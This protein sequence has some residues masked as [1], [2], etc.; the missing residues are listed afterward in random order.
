M[1]I[2]LV[3][4]PN[5]GKSQV[6]SKLT[7]IDTM[8]SNYSGTSLETT[9]G[10]INMSGVQ[11]ELVDTP[12]IYSL[13]LAEG[14]AGVTREI[15]MRKQDYDLIIN[16]VDA[17]KLGR[18]LA[19]TLELI[20][21]GL[22][23]IVLLNQIEVARN[24]HLE[25][26]QQKLS[27]SLGCPVIEFSAHTGEGMPKLLEIL[28][29][30]PDSS[31][32]TRQRV[33]LVAD[34]PACGCDGD[35]FRCFDDK[36]TGNCSEQA[37]FNRYQQARNLA[38]QVLL[39]SDRRIKKLERLEWF[40]DNTFWGTLVLL[41]LALIG[42]G[43]LLTFVGW[44][45]GL[46]SQLFEPVQGF[47]S[48]V[49]SSIIPPGFWNSILSKGVPEGLLIPFSLVMP[50]M[51]MVSFLMSLIEDIGLLPRYAVMLDRVGRVFGV[52]GQAVIPL[53]LGFGCRT[54]AVTATRILPSIGQRFIIITLLSIVIPCAGTIGMLASTIVALDAYTPVIVLTMTVV[55][56]LLGWV[57]KKIYGEEE[58]P[59][60]ELPSLRMP[61]T[62]N[63]L[64]KIKLRFQ[65]FFTEV[66][67]LLLV[68][69]VGVR[70]IIDSGVLN[71]LHHLEPI[72][73][74]LF[75]IPPEAVVGVLVTII[76]RYLA[77]LILLN[78]SLDP[79]EATI[80]I[81]MIA[82]SVPCLPVMVMTVKELGIK[83]LLKIVSLGFLVS[84]SI[85][86]GLNLLMP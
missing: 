62:Q 42:F 77:P 85:G 30:R 64:T 4:Q 70:I 22:P 83:A 73:S 9:R 1:T 8:V 58:E 57:L 21:L 50:A 68:M 69:S 74:W 18:N 45:E 71:R 20:E 61:Q 43:A 27:R 6:F 24:N 26:D 15:I 38:E 34:T 36:Q 78:L 19:L 55:F 86:I 29:K 33:V 28:S 72:T 46:V 5:S 48:R 25:I 13:A 16:V 60:Y 67:P 44:G 52:S 56:L 63:I 81:S 37:V 39:R 10:K 2:V 23:I 41:G 84:F 82:L 11:I 79:R 51:L 54:P 49:I 76:Q 65:G 80:A 59:I 35:C 75:G 3:G 32:R 14:P 53:S 47:I 40:L 12:G 31:D 66:L 17:N 7:G